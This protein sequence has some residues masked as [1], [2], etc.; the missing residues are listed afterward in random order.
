M[1]LRPHHE[2][3]LLQNYSD[4]HTASGFRRF[5]WYCPQCKAA[6]EGPP[7]QVGEYVVTSVYM[8][9]GTRPWGIRWRVYMRSQ[10]EHPQRVALFES[11]RKREA[12]KHARQLERNRQ[13]LTKALAGDPRA[14]AE[15]YQ[16]VMQLQQAEKN[17]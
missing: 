3:P 4:H 17:S 14:I 11:T 5:Q 12:I 13:H 8:R 2:H 15:N 6:I 16:Q 1:T 7:Y 9:E 10:I